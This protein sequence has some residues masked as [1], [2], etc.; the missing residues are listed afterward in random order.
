MKYKL[1]LG[2]KNNNVYELY[3][4]DVFS[5]NLESTNDYE[6]LEAIKSLNLD[7][8]CVNAFIIKSHFPNSKLELYIENDKTG[9]ITKRYNDM[10][11]VITSK[12]VKKLSNIYKKREYTYKNML[13]KSDVYLENEFSNMLN[14]LNKNKRDLEK[15]IR[16]AV[17]HTFLDNTLPNLPNNTID[18][19]FF[20]EENYKYIIKN[21]E[22]N[23]YINLDY[24]N[25]NF[26]MNSK[27][28]INK[29]IIYNDKEKRFYLISDNNSVCNYKIPYLD[30][31]KNPDVN[32]DRVFNKFKKDLALYNELQKSNKIKEYEELEDCKCKIN[33]Y[34]DKIEALSNEYLN[35]EQE[36]ELY[37][38]YSKCANVC[39]LYNTKLS[40]LKTNKEKLKYI[41]YSR[42]INWY[43]NVIKIPQFF[44]LDV[45]SLNEN[46]INLIKEEIIKNY[47]NIT[48]PNYIQTNSGN[49]KVDNLSCDIFVD[50]EEISNYL[51]LKSLNREKLEKFYKFKNERD[52]VNKS[53]NNINN[54]DKTQVFNK[55][56]EFHILKTIQKLKNIKNEISY[57]DNVLVIYDYE[58]ENMERKKKIIEN[59]QN[60]TYKI[61][62]V[63]N[64][65]CQRE[66]I[67]F[68]NIDFYNQISKINFKIDVLNNIKNKN[69]EIDFIYNYNLLSFPYITTDDI[70]NC[71][72][73]YKEYLY[74][75]NKQD[76]ALDVDLNYLM[77]LVILVC[78][79]LFTYKNII[80]LPKNVFNQSVVLTLNDNKVD[81]IKKVKTQICFS[82][83]IFHFAY[84]SQFCMFDFKNTN[85]KLCNNTFLNFNKKLFYKNVIST[86]NF[87]LVDIKDNANLFNRCKHIIMTYSKINKCVTIHNVTPY[88]C[89]VYDIKTRK[90]IKKFL[91]K[92]YA[93]FENKKYY[94]FF[95]ECNNI[96]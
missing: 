79:N 68:D 95:E 30:K 78:D 38:I 55:L 35:E 89:D 23:H 8:S 36:Y 61:T 21:S 70:K 90:H 72:V 6:L 15:R 96:R 94:T 59:I 84:L 69:K 45:N 49:E 5:F 27:N 83:D 26:K 67:N 51:E 9:R 7:V 47:N 85:S 1:T 12:I 60:G 77:Y 80:N 10:Y 18:K 71:V 42:L 29:N 53:L 58:C 16:K 87:H 44:T 57:N 14:N 74:E 50:V 2:F 66:M 91:L 73:K 41:N 40:K 34:N 56:K 22:T 54:I 81:S 4:D 86:K 3:S 13:V 20:I 11:D 75:Y 92:D 76:E 37:E 25:K 31:T 48:K 63:D 64:K 33:E 32:A 19:Y 39:D 43:K 24:K 46:D 17:V 65:Y 52:L 62:R 28:W 82:N 93:D 88:S